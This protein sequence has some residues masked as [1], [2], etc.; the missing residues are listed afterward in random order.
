MRFFSKIEMN[1]LKA[2]KIV[3]YLLKLLTLEISNK[4][5]AKI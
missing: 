5:L 1:S 4:K 3:N 2:P